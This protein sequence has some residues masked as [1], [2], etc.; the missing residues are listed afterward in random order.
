MNNKDKILFDHEKE[1][2]QINDYFNRLPSV[3]KQICTQK[4]FD[5][6]FS[7]TTRV[8]YTNNKITC[9]VYKDDNNTEY[10][11]QFRDCGQ[12]ISYKTMNH[13]QFQ[14]ISFSRNSERVLDFCFEWI[15]DQKFGPLISNT[16]PLKPNIPVKYFADVWFL[17]DKEVTEDQFRKYLQQQR[18]ELKEY[19]L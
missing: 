8:V 5:I 18:E 11:V 13:V 3:V 2:Q 6:I 16:R 9:I 1:H 7:S 15:D 12:K 17:F 10:M 19:N 14:G 4:D